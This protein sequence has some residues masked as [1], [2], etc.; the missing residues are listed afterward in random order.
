MVMTWEDEIRERIM[1]DDRWTP[2][3]PDPLSEQARQE[4][5]ALDPQGNRAPWIEERV[6]WARSSSPGELYGGD[7]SFDFGA[8]VT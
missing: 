3:P 4:L 6:T 7:T 1:D 2:G 5:A 8:N